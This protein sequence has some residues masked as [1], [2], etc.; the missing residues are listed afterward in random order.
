MITDLPNEAYLG[1]I[2]VT[3]IS[4]SFTCRMAAKINWHGS[5]TKLRHCHLVVNFFF[6]KL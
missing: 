1:A 5:A 6:K 4:E 3:N 2:T